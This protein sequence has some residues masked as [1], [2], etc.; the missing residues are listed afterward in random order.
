MSEKSTQIPKESETLINAGAAA[1]A[2]GTSP[3]NS[4]TETC[5]LAKC[6]PCLAVRSDA[7]KQ[8]IDWGF[9]SD[10]EGGQQLDGYV[11]AAND[12]N[13]GVTVGTGIDLG[14]R[15][16]TDINNLDISDDLK[17]KLKPYAS[18][19]K[20]DAQD[21]LKDHPLPL[22]SDEATSLDKA[23][24]KPIVDSLVKDYNAAVDAAN[25]KDG[26]KR[27]YFEQLPRGVQTAIAS[28]NFQYG[29]LSGP[30][31]N[32][33]KQVTEQRWQDASDN[34]KKFGDLYPTR[35]KL[36]ASLLDEAI[37]AVP[38]IELP[39]DTTVPPIK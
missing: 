11:P 26:C 16:E 9:I 33:W 36:E 6:P 12:S 35:R 1:E 23:V 5:P 31:P 8:D 20:K 24:K 30:T 34:L 37:K 18:K 39:V 17:T 29:S 19:Q 7:D 14:A 10:R 2:Q 4:A 13:S 32:Y 27:V 38:K 22:T 21:Y 25:K 28:T 3:V 15:S